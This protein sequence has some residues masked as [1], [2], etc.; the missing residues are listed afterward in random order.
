[1]GDITVDAV[2]F[3]LNSKTRLWEKG[4]AGTKMFGWNNRD[5][6]WFVTTYSKIGPNSERREIRFDVFQ[7]AV[8]AFMEVVV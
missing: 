5:E 4:I 2:F 7:D 3:K 6:K 1:M 8:N